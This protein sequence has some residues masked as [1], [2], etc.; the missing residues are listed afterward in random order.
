M[1]KELSKDRRVE[2]AKI[3]VRKALGRMA[4]VTSCFGTKRH[5]ESLD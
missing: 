4:N 3:R 5:F 1:E 2:R